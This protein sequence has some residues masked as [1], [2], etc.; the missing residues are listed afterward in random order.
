MSTLKARVI[1]YIDVM[2]EKKLAT[3]EPLLKLLSE[4]DSSDDPFYSEANQARLLKAAA[5]MKAGANIA[6][7]E[8]D[9]EVGDD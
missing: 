9:F 7:H 4:D 2:S 1:E 5:D 3:I 6:V 8:I